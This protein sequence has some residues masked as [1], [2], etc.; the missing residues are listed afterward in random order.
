MLKVKQSIDQMLTANV[1]LHSTKSGSVLLKSGNKR[2]TLVST[3]GERTALGSYYEQQSSNELRQKYEE[4]TLQLNNLQDDNLNLQK[5]YSE[6][7]SFLWE[8]TRNG[9]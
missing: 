3:T 1:N 5:T 8:M 9:K 7:L 2:H 4:K 6:I